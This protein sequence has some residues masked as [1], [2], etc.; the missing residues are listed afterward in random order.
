MTAYRAM[1]E[2]TSTD[3]APWHIVPADHKWVRDAVVTEVLTQTL[4]GLDLEVARARSRA[5]GAWSSP[6]LSGRQ[7]ASMVAM[8]SRPGTRKRKRARLPLWLAQ[9]SPRRLPRRMMTSPPA[10]Q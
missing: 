6:D 8:P 4:E 10:P 3:E 9:T 2:R 1:L 5:Q 7:R